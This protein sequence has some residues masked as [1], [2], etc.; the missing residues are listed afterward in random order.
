MDVGL[1]AG[2]L[3]INRIEGHSGP[4]HHIELPTSLIVRESCGAR[5]R[6]RRQNPSPA[7]IT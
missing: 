5:Q 1:R 6:V 2:H 3:L 4:P 7:L